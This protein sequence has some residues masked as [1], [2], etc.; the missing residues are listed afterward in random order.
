M[1]AAARPCVLV[2][3]RTAN[4]RFGSGRP[5]DVTGYRIFFGREGGTSSHDLHKGAA[6]MVPETT[7]QSGQTSD[8]EVDIKPHYPFGAGIIFLILEHSVYK[9]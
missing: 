9:M 1:L 3:V 8:K 7:Q 2:V 6:A 4:W 5:V